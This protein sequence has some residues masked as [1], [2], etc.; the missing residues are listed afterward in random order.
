MCPGAGHR[1]RAGSLAGRAVSLLWRPA[2]PWHGGRGGA[3]LCQGSRAGAAAGQRQHRWAYFTAAG[4]SLSLS[5]GGMSWP[6]GQGIG[7][8][9]Y[10]FPVQTLPPRVQAGAPASRCSLPI[11]CRSPCEG[12]MHRKGF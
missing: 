9:I 11:G 8:A 12:R 7:L 3:A 6:D 10:W 1:A 5:V 2:H 4:G